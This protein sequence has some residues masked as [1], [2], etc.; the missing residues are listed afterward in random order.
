MIWLVRSLTVDKWV[1][2][3]THV[4]VNA[5]RSRLPEQQRL[6]MLYLSLTMFHKEIYEKSARLG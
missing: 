1:I 5:I 4:L 2:K 3:N 6:R